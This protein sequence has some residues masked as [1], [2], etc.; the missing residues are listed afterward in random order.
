MNQQSTP[1]NKPAPNQFRVVERVQ[2]GFIVVSA[3]QKTSPAEGAG[4]GFQFLDINPEGKEYYLVYPY[5]ETYMDPVS[6]D[7]SVF[8]KYGRVLG[9]FSECLLMET[10]A[11]RLAEISEYKI[12]MVYIDMDYQPSYGINNSYEEYSNTL[13]KEWH[14]Q[15]AQH[16]PL[17]EEM[18]QRVNRD[19]V[20]QFMRDL[21]NIHNRD[22]T[23]RWNRD[24]ALPYIAQKLEA[25][26]CDVVT[27][28]IPGYAPLIVG[29]RYGKVDP[30]LSK[31]VLLGGHPDTRLVGVGSNANQLRHQGANDN[32]TGTVGF[33][34]AARVHQHYDFDYT[35]I[36]AGFN[37][38]E[39]GIH[40]SR[41]LM[42]Y[43]KN[44]GAQ[45][46]G[47][48]FSY[49]MF[50]MTG[51]RLELLVYDQIP[52][53]TA[54]INR[55][56]EINQLYNAYARVSVTTNNSPPTDIRHIW[57]NGY[58]GAMNAVTFTGGGE[59]HTVAD[60]INR[61][62]SAAHIAN[63]C[64]IGIAVTAH[65]AVPRPKGGGTITVTAPNGGEIIEVGSSFNIRWSSNISAQQVRISLMRGDTE[66]AEI[67]GNAPN[68]GSYTWNVSQNLTAGSDYR[69]KIQQADNSAISGIS[70]NKFT[71]RRSVVVDT[72]NPSRNL[73]FLAS[74]YTA[75]D[76]F[77]STVSLDTSRLATDSL[78]ISDK[79][80]VEENRPDDINPWALTGVHLDGNLGEVE[81]IKI[82]YRSNNPLQLTLDQEGLSQSGTS[83]FAQIPYSQSWDTL[84]LKVD[85][86]QFRQ[87]DWV[88]E[89]Q[90]RN[91]NLNE[92]Q[93]ISFKA[94]GSNITTS[95]EISR[96]ILYGYEPPVRVGN[97]SV[98]QYNAG[99]RIGNQII[100]LPY[101]GTWEA[102]IFTSSGRLVSRETISINS[103]GI[104]NL[105]AWN[106][107]SGLYIINLKQGST[108]IRSTFIP[109]R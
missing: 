3:S 56:R 102:E 33:L 88:N 104:H 24:Y 48:A 41:V 83:Y 38:E 107:K 63:S 95:L 46:L 58:V 13:V 9:A 91:L 32:A 68:T 25:Y 53:S 94:S 60:S 77:G 11:K 65:Y 103:V 74:W 6:Y 105:N 5:G 85:T 18:L 79:S 19:S 96:V 37:A 4:N 17:I 12:K 90:R 101:D 49:D 55:I 39:Y 80:L 35:I 54:F 14:L 93:S 108:E 69:I 43:L 50:G 100:N 62:Y 23:A 87:P 26:G 99:L 30:S 59:I 97:R 61:N 15:P 47:G 28:P 40:G 20:T 70:D 89:S 2:D 57:G 84:L 8:E 81:W 29:I 31:F 34:E 82:V 10:T 64:K 98:K 22:A 66:I 106:F 92:V 76:N 21:C 7:I 16:N 42:E 109:T 67:A 27:L 71:I 75:A 45:V 72:A 73:L 52:G 1:Y 36:Y 51:N 78:I 44:A 86:I